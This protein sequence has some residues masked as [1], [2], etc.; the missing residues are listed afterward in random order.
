MKLSTKLQSPTLLVL[1]GFIAGA[2]VFFTLQPLSG[3]ETPPPTA[4]A[5]SVLA[6]IQA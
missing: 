4:A 1:Q 5:P 3:A 6:D 2:V